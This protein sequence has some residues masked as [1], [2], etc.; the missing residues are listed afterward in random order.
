MT[1]SFSVTRSFARQK[2]AT[3][4][5]LPNLF[6]CSIL[7]PLRTISWWLVINRVC[8]KRK[9]LREL[10]IY[11]V[12]L[13]GFILTSS[14]SIC[15]NSSWIITKFF[16]IIRIFSSETFFYFTRNYSKHQGNKKHIFFVSSTV[17]LYISIW[18]RASPV[19]KI[20]QNS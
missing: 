3:G 17:N 1:N 7:L 5:T 11:G 9:E 10:P 15:L 4:R 6:L 18:R 8:K 12:V 16:S 14:I 13:Y 20:N 2:I 19:R